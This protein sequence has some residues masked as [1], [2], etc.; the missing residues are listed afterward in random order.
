[1]ILTF[2]NDTLSNIFLM[3]ASDRYKFSDI[4]PGMYVYEAAQTLSGR[5]WKKIGENSS[6]SLWQARVNGISCRLSLSK[7]GSKVKQIMVTPG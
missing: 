4:Y 6:M 3:K 5:N 2:N 7:S 1:M